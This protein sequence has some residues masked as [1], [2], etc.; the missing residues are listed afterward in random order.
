MDEEEDVPSTKS[1]PVPELLISLTPKIEP[2]PPSRRRNSTIAHPAEHYDPR[3]VLAIVLDQPHHAYIGIGPNLRPLIEFALNDLRQEMSHSSSDCRQHACDKDADHELMEEALCRLELE[4]FRSVIPL[5]ASIENL[6]CV[7]QQERYTTPLLKAVC[8]ALLGSFLAG[9]NTS[10]LNVPAALIQQDCRLS[11]TAFSSLQSFYC[12]GGLVGALVAGAFSDR[13]GRRI[14]LLLANLLFM[15]SGFVSLLYTFNVFGAIDEPSTSLIYFLFSRVVSGV[16]SGISTAL[17]PTYLGE[18]SPAIIRGQIGTM[19]AFVNGF[20][21]LFAELICF[22]YLL[23]VSSRWRYIFT[24]NIIPFVV[25]LLFLASFCESPQW[26]LFAEQ[27]QRAKRVFQ[28]LRQTENVEFDMK[29]METKRYHASVDHV[30][31]SSPRHL[32]HASDHEHH[33]QHPHQPRQLH[34]SQTASV[35]TKPLLDS[36]GNDDEYGALQTSRAH[37]SKSE[38]KNSSHS[39]GESNS[40]QRIKLFYICFI[41]ISLQMLQQLSGINSV[42]YYSS[43]MLQN[44]GLTS[45]IQLWLGNVLLA[46]TNFFGVLIPVKLVEKLGRKLLLYLSCAGMMMASVAL[47]AVLMFAKQLGDA[48]GYLSIIILVAYVVSFAMGLGPIVGLLTVELSPSENRGTIVSVAFFINYLANLLVA[49]YANLV[50]QYIF[51]VPFAGICLIGIAFTFF[52]LVETKGQKENDIQRLLARK[53]SGGR[54][55]QPPLDDEQPRK[56]KKKQKNKW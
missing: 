36:H 8:H 20:G 21:I 34:H 9:Y 43:I 12:I 44:A 48:S 40:M 27:K 16:A 46:A 22:E 6:E 24:L 45:S 52:C 13:Y 42:W 1:E 51:Y 49:Q 56:H 38:H 7:L 29:S 3:K 10:L 55:P 2:I 37:H 35:P 54:H 28:W 14:T 50:V 30:K 11:I 4:G 15:L 39:H 26:L 19:N 33:Q 32:Q 23:G 18:I 25:Q 47:S 53:I 5:A 31:H 17:V 41:T